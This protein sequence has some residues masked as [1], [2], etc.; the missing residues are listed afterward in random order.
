V[1]LTLDSFIISHIGQAFNLFVV[2]RLLQFLLSSSCAGHKGGERHE[3]YAM[4]NDQQRTSVIYNN[5]V[6]AV[7]FLF[8]GG[9][10]GLK[11]ATSYTVL[12]C[13]LT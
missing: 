10:C 2:D 3:V 12:F 13:M 8:K 4:M 5:G 7:H 11:L 9:C 6:K 1:F